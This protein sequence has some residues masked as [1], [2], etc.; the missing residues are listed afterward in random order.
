M[1]MFDVFGRMTA[2]LYER[3]NCDLFIKGKKQK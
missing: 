3:N 1:T 2:K